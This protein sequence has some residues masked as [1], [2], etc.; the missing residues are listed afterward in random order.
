M[1][2]SQPPPVAAARRGSSVAGS[3]AVVEAEDHKE[4]AAPDGKFLFARE[5][6]QEAGQSKQWI[7]SG[8][9]VR[10]ICRITNA[11]Y[12]LLEVIPD[13]AGDEANRFIR[14]I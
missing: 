11:L 12:N 13:V 5:R 10:H 14:Y 2:T 1:H 6:T 9:G 8:S 4:G 7:A 3:F